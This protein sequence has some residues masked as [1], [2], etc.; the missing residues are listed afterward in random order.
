M[1]QKLNKV[2]EAIKRIQ[3]SRRS[4]H[5]GIKNVLFMLVDEIENLQPKT[6][7][8]NIKEKVDLP[9]DLPPKKPE[10]NIKDLLDELTKGDESGELK[11]TGEQVGSVLPD[12]LQSDSNEEPLSVDPEGSDTGKG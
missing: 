5:D 8:E 4:Q 12:D 9:L 2:R 11:G 1:T 7:V 10:N 3:K 6:I